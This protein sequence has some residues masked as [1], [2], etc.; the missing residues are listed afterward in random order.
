MLNKEW[1]YQWELITAYQEYALN[2]PLN[3]MLKIQSY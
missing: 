1:L 2:F 3:I